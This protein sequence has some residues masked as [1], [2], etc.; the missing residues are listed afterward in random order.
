[1]DYLTS[2][3][4]TKRDDPGKA[5]ILTVSVDLVSDGSEEPEGNT[6]VTILLSG[7]FDYRELKGTGKVTVQ[8][9]TN[10][11]D[12][13]KRFGFTG[14]GQD[15][16]GRNAYDGFVYHHAFSSTSVKGDPAVKVEFETYEEALWAGKIGVVLGVSFYAT[17]SHK[18]AKRGVDMLDGE[19]AKLFD[20]E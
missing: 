19:L 7:K 9:F 1:M 15:S 16:K 2:L 20:N 12:E 4:T 3:V 13:I 5:D 11:K 8:G 14:R 18:R 6:L 17:R 10:I